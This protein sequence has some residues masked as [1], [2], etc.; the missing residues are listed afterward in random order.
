MYSFS[1]MRV[2]WYVVA[3]QKYYQ[4]GKIALK[5]NTKRIVPKYKFDLIVVNEE[6]IKHCIL[7]VYIIICRE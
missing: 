2:R 7:F 4:N 6:T 3:L 5:Y 1:I